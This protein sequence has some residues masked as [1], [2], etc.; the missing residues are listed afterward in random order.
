MPLKQ[1]EDFNALY[2]DKP[3]FDH[4]VKNKQEAYE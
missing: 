4:P 3:I 2:D 1:I